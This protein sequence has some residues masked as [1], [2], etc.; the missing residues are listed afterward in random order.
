MVLFCQDDWHPR[1]NLRYELVGLPVMI[2]QVRNLLLVAGSFYLPR[3]AC[4][5]KGRMVFHPDRSGD[6]P[7]AGLFPFVEAV[8][9]YQTTPLLEAESNG[10]VATRWERSIR[11]SNCWQL[12]RVHQEP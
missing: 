4:E 6:F 12:E 1:T 7:T 3:E 8:R 5:N 10:L 11:Q 2:V 9:W